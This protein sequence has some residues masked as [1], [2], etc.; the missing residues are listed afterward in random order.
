MNDG[1]L[2]HDARIQDIEEFKST[3]QGAQGTELNFRDSYKFNIAAYRL[4][5]LINLKMVPVSGERKIGGNSSSVTWWLDDIQ[6]ME[7]ERYQKKITPPDQD[8][9]NHH[10]YNVRGFNELAYNT[11]PNLGNVLITNDWDIWLIDYS[12]GVRTRR[13]SASRRTTH[14]L[15]PATG[16]E[17]RAGCHL[18]RTSLRAGRLR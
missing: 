3:F 6:M 5:R 4:D 9:W 2:R 18:G 10:M 12:R 15:L 16:R 14:G 11:D 17:Q 7:L 1:R 13:T 8:D